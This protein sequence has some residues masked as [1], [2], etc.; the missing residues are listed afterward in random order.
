MTYAAS[1]REDMGGFYNRQIMEIPDYKVQALYRHLK[2]IV[3]NVRC[4]PADTRTIDALRLARLDM[5]DLEKRIH[6]KRKDV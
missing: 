2:R 5:R 4:S 6:T 3:E 1:V